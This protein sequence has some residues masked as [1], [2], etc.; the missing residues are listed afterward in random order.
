MQGDHSDSGHAQGR[1]RPAHR[2]SA[3]TVRTWSLDLPHGMAAAGVVIAFLLASRD[4]RRRTRVAEEWDE[5]AD[6]TP[7]IHYV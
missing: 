6:R 4:E 3:G 2:A 7:P 1:D 5:D